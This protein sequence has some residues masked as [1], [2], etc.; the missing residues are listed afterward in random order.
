MS[1]TAEQRRPAGPPE[2]APAVPEIVA[3]LVGAGHLEA[4]WVNEAGGVTWRVPEARLYVKWAPAAGGLDLRVEA[5]RM[6]WAARYTPVPEVLDAG[7]EAEGSW[8][9]TAAIEASSAVSAAWLSEPATAVAAVGVGLRVLHD[10]LPVA[11]CPWSWSVE[12]RVAASARLAAEQGAAGSPDAL[13]GEAEGDLS[14]LGPPPEVD[15]LVVCHGDACCPNTLLDQGGHFAAHVDL[16]ALGV[17]DRWADLAVAT[18]STIWNYGA[19][20]EEVLLDAYGVDPD[21]DR[22]RYYRRLWDLT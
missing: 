14:L 6:A 3:A 1:G 17:A 13:A 11:E 5:E 20:W 2:R 21:A 8:L 4:V 15:R 7:A 9:V 19:G 18:Y 10:A 22:T 16:A 12:S